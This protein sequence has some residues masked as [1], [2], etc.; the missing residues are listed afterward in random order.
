M[1]KI[2]LLKRL[3][4][5]G[6]NAKEGYVKMDEQNTSSR[7]CAHLD[8]FST[9]LD[10]EAGD[11]L[12]GS[13]WGPARQSGGEGPQIKWRAAIFTALT[14]ALSIVDVS[15]GGSPPASL[16]GDA[17]VAG[18]LTSFDYIWTAC[19]RICDY[20]CNVAVSALVKAFAK[21][22]AWRSRHRC[23][24]FALCF[25]SFTAV[26]ACSPIFAGRPIWAAGLP[27]IMLVSC[28]AAY[29]DRVFKTAASVLPSA[30]GKLRGK[31][32][33]RRVLREQPQK[34]S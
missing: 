16:V 30:F 8:P 17:L 25:S 11:A 18:L 29:G 6:D 2:E 24:V 22:S 26:E 4:Q 19:S 9:N 5:K 14:A 3:F 21:V 12:N 28:G 33:M 32:C 13:R 34:E 31:G 10:G 1:V 20:I 15:C 7:I 27:L 23:W